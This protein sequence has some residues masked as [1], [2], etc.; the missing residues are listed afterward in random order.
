MNVNHGTLIKDS[1][2]QQTQTLLSLLTVIKH[3]KC[4]RKYGS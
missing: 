4:K 1:N 3:Y 2:D